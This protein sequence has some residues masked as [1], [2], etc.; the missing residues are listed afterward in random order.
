MEINYTK[1]LLFASLSG[2]ISKSIVAPLERIKIIFQTNHINLTQNSFK[3]TI[4][5]IIKT[6]GGINK[7]WKGNFINI[8]KIIPSSMNLCF[9]KYYKNKL[10]DKN[11]IMSTKNGY[12]TGIF[13]GLSRNIILYPFETV[14]C[15]VTSKISKNKSKNI[16]YDNVKLY[17]LKSFYK[18]FI[19]STLGAI[20]YNG[21]LWGTYFYLNNINIFY[22][23][24]T[25]FNKSINI[26]ISTFLSQII[27]YPIDVWKKRIQKNITEKDQINILKETIKEKAL[28]KGLSINLIK[29]PILYTISFSIFNFMEINL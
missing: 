1:T 3:N 11:G 24:D 7:L 25:A 2:I 16:I 29:T 13:T 14:I 12:L 26:Y 22:K 9:Q 18:G 17:G 5:E 28:Y 27:V 8:V 23:K 6:E 21:I 15:W 20:P 19:V 4:K 10:V